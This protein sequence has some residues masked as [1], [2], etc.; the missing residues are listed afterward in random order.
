M[1]GC[2]VG[3]MDIATY[4][5][6]TKLSQKE[7]GALVKVTQGRVSQWIKGG[8]VPL[9]K[10]QLIEART[11]GKVTRYDLRPKFPW[12]RVVHGSDTRELIA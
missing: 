11:E 8:K 2:N 3:D 9:D 6:Q 12:D 7:F 1:S 4:L 5:A 10:I